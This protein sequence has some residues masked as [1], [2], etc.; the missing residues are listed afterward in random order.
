MHVSPALTFRLPLYAPTGLVATGGST[1]GLTWNVSASGNYNSTGYSIERSAD[2]L[3]G[4]TQIGRVGVG[5]RVFTDLLPIT[6]TNYYRVRET[7]L[8]GGGP[9]SSVVSAN[10]APSTPAELQ[11]QY[12]ALAGVNGSTAIFLAE[13]G[14]PGADTVITGGTTGHILT[15]RKNAFNLTDGNALAPKSG[16]TGAPCTIDSYGNTIQGE[17]LEVPTSFDWASLIGP[18]DNTLTNQVADIVPNPLLRTLNCGWQVFDC[19]QVLENCYLWQTQ[20]GDGTNTYGVGNFNNIEMMRDP[21]AGFLN[22]ALSQTQTGSKLVLSDVQFVTA[23]NF[24]GDTGATGGTFTFWGF[25]GSSLE[26]GGSYNLDLQATNRSLQILVPGGWQVD[27]SHLNCARHFLLLVRGCANA[28]QV[29]LVR[30][31]IKRRPWAQGVLWTDTRKHFSFFGD[32]EQQPRKSFFTDREGNVMCP[33]GHEIRGYMGLPPLTGWT[34]SL[35]ARSGN[36]VSRYQSC[37]SYRCRL[38]DFSDRPRVGFIQHEIVNDG[39]DTRNQAWC[40]DTLTDP[41]ISWVAV[42]DTQSNRGNNDAYNPVVYEALYVPGHARAMGRIFPSLVYKGWNWSATPTVGDLHGASGPWTSGNHPITPNTQELNTP[43]FAHIVRKAEGMDTSGLTWE[44]W[45]DTF[46]VTLT[47]GS[48]TY[49]PVWTSKREDLSANPA[50]SGQRRFYVRN[51]SIAT[52]DSVTGQ[53]TSVAVGSTVV[54][55]FDPVGGPGGMGGI[56]VIV[57]SL[58]AP[59]E[60][61]TL[62][63]TADAS[64]TSGHSLNGALV[65]DSAPTF[66]AAV[67]PLTGNALT[68]VRAQH[69]GV[70]ITDT[71]ALRLMRV[72][73]DGWTIKGTL[74]FDRILDGVIAGFNKDDGS[75][76]RREIFCGPISGNGNCRLEVYGND[77]AA[78]ATITLPAGTLVDGGVYFFDARWDRT[79]GGANGTLYFNIYSNNG[80]VLVSALGTP[81][82][83]SGAPNPGN[84]APFR[85]C[86]R[87]STDNFGLS[88]QAQRFHVNDRFESDAEVAATRMATI[89]V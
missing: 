56:S 2:G 17:G 70:E 20:K 60:L 47:G 11:T 21:S 49:T 87:V 6:G 65:G 42:Y 34:G 23:P 57:S 50:V 4:W 89:G 86:K 29:A 54:E 8:A 53:I 16:F 64:D 51:P 76:G 82:V 12:N 77:D 81:A 67:S 13:T 7:N 30:S 5:V 74:K 38:R 26:D 44:V 15:A 52:V 79:T 28:A 36:T 14:I 1:I 58:P 24:N 69:Q 10:T 48:P 25:D 63:L 33:L 66:T 73:Q 68:T 27:G 83:L 35:L 75:A 84:T 22:G 39:S 9:Y 88:G 85:V 46:E 78:K 41:R 18:T 59:P 55:T 62:P 45:P 61:V 43:K 80:G 72:G 40:D 31:Y 71:T 37:F 32:S 3:T 19:G